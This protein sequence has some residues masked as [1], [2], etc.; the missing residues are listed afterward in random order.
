MP[1]CW[2]LEINITSSPVPP[3]KKVP[4]GH[5]SAFCKLSK[6]SNFRPLETL[7]HLGCLPQM[8]SNSLMFFW[9]R[10]TQ[11]CTQDLAGAPSAHCRAGQSPSLS[12]W[13][14]CARMQMHPSIQLTLFVDS[15]SIFHQPRPP[16]FFLW[17][18][19]PSICSL[20]YAYKQGYPATHGESALVFPYRW[21][22]SSFLVFPHVSVRPLCPQ[23]TWV[24]FLLRSWA[25]S[26]CAVGDGVTGAP[27]GNPPSHKCALTFPHP[28]G[29]RRRMRKKTK[30]K[31][32]NL[33]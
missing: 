5:P 8:H 9:Y 27:A 11:N 16:G 4:W 17:G 15:Y 24:F 22:L 32:C 25:C 20:L 29:L 12:S 13:W 21:Q 6:P 1:C 30:S 23:E 10:G 28:R 3:L 14:C 7:H 2:S 33:R 26:E 18:C 19:C 31:T